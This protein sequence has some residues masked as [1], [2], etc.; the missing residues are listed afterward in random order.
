MS[1]DIVEVDG[2]RFPTKRFACLR[3]PNLKPSR[4]LLMVS[5]DLS[6]FGL[7]QGSSDMKH[8]H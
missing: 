6:N 5:I 7:L 1:T 3:G 4:D 8:T 2:L